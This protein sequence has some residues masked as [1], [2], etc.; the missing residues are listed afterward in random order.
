MTEPLATLNDLAGQMKMP[1]STVTD[2]AAKEG[3]PHV[4]IGRAKRFTPEQVAQIIAT[5][6]VIA[7]AQ[8]NVVELAGQ[9][10]RSAAAR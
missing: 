1:L 9:T 3:W 10:K 7:K 6:T 8:E 2:I 5:H 4:K